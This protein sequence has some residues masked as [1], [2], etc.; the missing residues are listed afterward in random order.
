MRGQII[1]GLPTDSELRRRCIRALRKTCG[2]HGVL[3][4]SHIVTF[5]LSRPRG[6]SFASGGFSDVWKLTDEEH[7]D[8]VFAVKSFRV[9]EQDPVDKI[10][11]VWSFSIH[12]LAKGQPVV[13]YQEI[14]QGG[15]SSQA[16]ESPKHPVDRRR[17][18]QAVRVLHGVS[19]DA[20]WKYIGICEKVPRSQSLGTGKGSRYV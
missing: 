10:N 6:R 14:L 11:K 19:V 9:Y 3:P 18:T 15:Y 7:H 2:L 17:G 4:T 5:T 16:G 8:R 20:E 13:F 1:D 12:N